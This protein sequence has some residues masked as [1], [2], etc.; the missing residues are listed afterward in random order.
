MPRLTCEWV[1]AI[2]Q[3]SDEHGVTVDMNG[4]R[5]RSRWVINCT[6][7]GLG[8]IGIPIRASIKLELGELTI[9]PPASRA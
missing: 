8:S 4:Q 6:Y 1:T 3:G 5:V 7:S 2:I 9:D